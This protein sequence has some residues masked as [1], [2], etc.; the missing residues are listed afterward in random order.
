M[1]SPVEKGAAQCA[2]CHASP[3]R[4]VCLSP[5][6]VS[7]GTCAPPPR[8][9]RVRGSTA[10]AGSCRCRP[11]CPSPGWQPETR[12]CHACTGREHIQV[13]H[14][15]QQLFVAPDLFDQGLRCDFDRSPSGQAKVTIEL[16]PHSV[17]AAVHSQPRNGCSLCIEHVQRQA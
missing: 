10:S 7:Q 13:T 4:R 16:L 17:A 11:A 9:P 8:P 2:P 15:L 3:R 1:A 6:R 12:K 14:H 5:K